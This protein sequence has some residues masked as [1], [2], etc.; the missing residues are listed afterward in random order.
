MFRFLDIHKINSKFINQYFVIMSHGGVSS[1]GINSTVIITKEVR[2][3]IIEQKQPFNIIIY[4]VYKILK[5][6]EQKK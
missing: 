4:I 3:S 1:S 5:I 2:N 6:I